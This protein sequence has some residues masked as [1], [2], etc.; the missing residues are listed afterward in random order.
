MDIVAEIGNYKSDNNVTILQAKRW[1]NIINKRKVIAKTFGV[2][3]ALVEKILKTIHEESINI[4]THIL[5]RK[6][7]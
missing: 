4:Q 7:G 2:S 6:K 1:E 5:N 3:E